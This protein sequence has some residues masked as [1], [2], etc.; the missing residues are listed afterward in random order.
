MYGAPFAAVAAA[1]LMSCGREKEASR[2]RLPYSA[3]GP[4]NIN[5]TCGVGGASTVGLVGADGTPAWAVERNPDSSIVWLVAANV[6]INSI[7]SKDGNPLP[8]DPDGDQGGRPGTA[9]RSKVRRDAQAAEYRY[10]IDVTCQPSSGQPV[11]LVIDPSLFVPDM[12]VR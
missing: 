1:L 4:I 6:T 2:S 11:R 10:A 8:L 7:R 12:I 3:A 9:Y 5:F